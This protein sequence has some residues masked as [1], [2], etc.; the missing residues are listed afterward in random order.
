MDWIFLSFFFALP[1]YLF[2]ASEEHKTENIF[3]FVFEFVHA[4][5]SHW[6]SALS[7]TFK[8]QQKKHQ[9]D[10]RNSNNNC[11]KK[12]KYIQKK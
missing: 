12:K 3:I 1:P 8:S 7:A 6:F 2:A 10:L 5:A 9:N 4:F 11:E